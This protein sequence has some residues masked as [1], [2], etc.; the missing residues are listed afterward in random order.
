MASAPARPGV[1]RHR[2]DELALAAGV[3]LDRARVNRP[4]VQWQL[5]GAVK[6]LSIN[7]KTTIKPADKA[8]DR[9]PDYRMFHLGVEMDVPDALEQLLGRAFPT[10]SG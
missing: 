9:A 3:G 6:T 2:T 7:A 4:A 8:D 10:T 5:S 1:G